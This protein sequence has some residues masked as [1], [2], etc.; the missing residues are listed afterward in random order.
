MR[1]AGMPCAAQ[2]TIETCESMLSRDWRAVRIAGNDI[3]S[4]DP[5][6]EGSARTAFASL[7]K[8]ARP[9][10]ESEPCEL[11]GAALTANHQHLL[12]SAER[13][14]LCACDACAILLS[15]GPGSKYRRVPRRVKFWPDFRLTDIQWG[16]LNLPIDMAFFFYST[17]LGKV[18]ALYPGPGGAIE[19]IPPEDAW[20]QLVADNPLLGEMEPD[21]EALLVNRVRGARDAY[22]APVDECYRLVGII[23]NSWRGFS[24]GTEVWQEIDKFFADLKRRSESSL[25]RRNA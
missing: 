6:S 3:M 10:A 11:C 14:L 22:H 12:N 19:S 4:Y 17:E 2:P 9:P 13:K 20:G 18:I 15:G 1:N 16:S 24:G 8:F 5:S 21:V 23:R 25:G 7:R